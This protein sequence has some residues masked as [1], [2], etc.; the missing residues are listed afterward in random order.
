MLLNRKCGIAI[1]SL[2]DAAVKC[3]EQTDLVARKHVMQFMVEHMAYFLKDAHMEPL[4]SSD[5]S[6]GLVR[7]VQSSYLITLYL[8]VKLL[9]FANV[10]SQI[11]AMNHL[12]DADYSYYGLH[13][14]GKLMRGESWAVSETFP[15]VTLCDFSVRVV[16]QHQRYTA[17]C[18]L[19]SNLLHEM[20]YTFLWFWFVFV[21]FCTCGSFLIW[22]MRIIFLPGVEQYI[23][24]R[25]IAGIN[26]DQRD[27]LD[28]YEAELVRQFIFSYLRRD[29]LFLTWLVAKNTS[30][31]VAAEFICSMFKNYDGPKPCPLIEKGLI[32][33][34]Y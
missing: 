25:L 28:P 23:T 5:L 20:I 8:I 32:Q 27:P 29:G 33:D 15:R 1:N 16:G 22:C 10:T 12:L 19:P 11:W 34:Y 4:E 26:I 3:Q 18:A 13:M 14:V 24:S 2:T 9:Y 30:D 21:A 31:V 17:Q 7:I 6:R